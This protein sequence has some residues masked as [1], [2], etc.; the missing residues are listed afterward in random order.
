MD[1]PELCIGERLKGIRQERG[2]SLEELARQTSVSKPMLGQIER[3][4]SAPT[5]T[6]LWKIATGL[7]IPLSSLLQT[8]SQTYSVVRF[9]EGEPIREDDGRMRAYTVFPFDPTRSLEVFYIELD[10]GCSHSSPAHNSGVEEYV[11]VIQG[12]LELTLSG[13]AVP[14]TEHEAM[15]F[16]ADLPHG[17]HNPGTELCTIYNVILYPAT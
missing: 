1:A 15:R 14:V 8:A 7:R 13:R 6:T 17:Y 12:C 16:R 4:Q 2:L 3:G 5:I 10:P 11:L 9:P